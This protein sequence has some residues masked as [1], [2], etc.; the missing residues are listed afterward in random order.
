MERSI[1]YRAWSRLW[2]RA[3]AVL[4]ALCILTVHGQSMPPDTISV[5]VRLVV[6]HA[7][8]QNRQGAFISG[9]QKQNFKIYEDGK[10]QK[11]RLLQSEDTAAAIGLVID[12]SGSM[13]RKRPDVIAAALELARLS[14]PGDEVFAVNFNERVTFGLQYTKLFSTSPAELQSAIMKPL[15]GGRTALYDAI[16]AALTHIDRSASERKALVVVSDGGDNASSETL[17]HVLREVE[18]SNVMVYTIGLFD[19]EDE[20]QNAGVLRR[21]AGASGGE[22]FLPAKPAD[23]AQVCRRI[24]QDIRSQYTLTYSPSN[25]EFHGGYRAIKISVV[26]DGGARLRARTRAGYVASPSEKPEA[27]GSQAVRR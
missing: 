23:A 11:I 16:H 13:Q 1:A 2:L 25:Q 15:P 9:L 5:D 19:K 4:P 3:L 20:D 14:N 12:S 24:A 18:T 7:S 10:P 21:I 6:L 27:A 26:E 22:A 8:V 17:A